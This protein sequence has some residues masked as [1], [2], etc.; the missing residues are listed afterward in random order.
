MDTPRFSRREL[1]RR[2]GFVGAA[3]VAVTTTTTTTTTTTITVMTIWH[4]EKTGADLVV[5]LPM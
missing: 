1:L 5:R 2:A 4:G 3:A